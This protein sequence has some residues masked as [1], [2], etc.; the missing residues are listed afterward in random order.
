MRRGNM[1]KQ[2]DPP[3]LDAWDP[4][5]PNELFRR[6]RGIEALWHVV[7]G[8]AL[9][10]WHGFETRNHED[11]EI[12]ILRDD[13]SIFRHALPEMRF[14]C[15]GSGQVR[16]LP[17]DA[18]PP[19]SVHQVWCLEAEAQKWKLD[20]ML[21]P[22]TRDEWVFRRDGRIR[23]RRSD[24]VERTKDGMPFLNPAG[25]LLFKAKHRRPKDEL[26][27]ENTIGKLV[28]S[29]CVW[30]KTGLGQAHPGHEWIV[31]L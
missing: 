28:A 18:E 27:F 6:L 21:E 1:D 10:L 11:I 24:M 30:L 2:L 20:I 13:F 8:W 19:D 12:A 7:G 16:H 29:E 4:F 5:L 25:V 17:P 3:G 15:A 14:Y 23:R 26:D 22:G 31:R 9:D